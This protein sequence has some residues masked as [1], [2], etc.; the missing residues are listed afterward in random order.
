[1]MALTE[2]FLLQVFQLQLQLTVISVNG[3][4]CYRYH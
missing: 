3:H 2:L 4:F 1:M